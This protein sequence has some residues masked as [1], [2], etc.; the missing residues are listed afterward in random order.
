MAFL[1]Q[2]NGFPAGTD[3]GRRT[4]ELALVDIVGK[5]G[6]RALRPGSG[7]RTV[8]C[9]TPE[10]GDAWTLTRASAPVRTRSSAASLPGPDVDR[11]KTTPLGTRTLRLTNAK[12]GP[13]ARRARRSRSRGS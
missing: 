10:A 5:D 2:Y 4:P 3:A 1:L 6:P 13:E 12:P 9:L 11:A 8:G 7:V